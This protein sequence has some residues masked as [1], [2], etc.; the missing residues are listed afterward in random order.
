MTDR[1]EH[2]L[3][4]KKTGLIV[5]R[6]IG[7]RNFIDAGV[8][9]DARLSYDLLVTILT[10]RRRLTTGP[11]VIQKEAR[12]L[13][14]PLTKISDLTRIHLPPCRDRH[15]EARCHLAGRRRKLPD[16]VCRGRVVHE[17]WTR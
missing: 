17:I 7:L 16:H 11:G 14:L 15:H 12:R 2:T 4:S 6:N 3:A 1:S 9:L 5:I 10:H 13:V 8:Q